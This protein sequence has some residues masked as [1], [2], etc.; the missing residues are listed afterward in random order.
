M[1][2]SKLQEQ[3]TSEQQ[4]SKERLERVL[5]ENRVEHEKLRS[6]LSEKETCIHQ[7]DTKIV[8]ERTKYQ[9]L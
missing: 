7:L 1:M 9:S 6:L 8:E 3:L 5:Q 2:E 4:Q